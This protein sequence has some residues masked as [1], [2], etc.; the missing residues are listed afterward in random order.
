MRALAVLP[1]SFSPAMLVQAL[2]ISIVNF[3]TAGAE[4]PPESLPLIREA[5]T[6]LRQLPPGTVIEVSGHTD[7]T[8]DPEINRTLSQRRAEAVRAALVA[9]GAPADQLVAKGYGSG[10]P[11]ADNATEDGRFRNRR[12]EYRV[13]G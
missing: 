9:G 1:G 11:V 13:G 5:A 8:G 10:Q 7:N 3:P 4:I 2:N 6:R 12:I